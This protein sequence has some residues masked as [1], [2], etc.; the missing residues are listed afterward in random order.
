MVALLLGALV[1]LAIPSGDSAEKHRQLKTAVDDLDRALRFAGNE[2]VLRNSV[3]RLR[4]S[5]DKEPVEYTVEYGP[6]GNLP[7][8]DSALVKATQSLEEAKAEQDKSAKLNQQFTK[9][10]EFED[11]KHE[12]HDNVTIAGVA[13]S[14]QKQLMTKG[15][16]NLYFY[17][18]GEKDGGVIFFATSEE[19]AFLEIEPFMTETKNFFEALNTDSA[20]KFNDIL[21]SKMQEVYNQW[22]KD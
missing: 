9:V 14:S 12:I 4:I 11:I 21:D 22:L 18:T 15:D 19:F 7:L 8:P 10:E 13:S 1:F 16:A 2:A 17:P 5:L 6:A 3:V 20:A